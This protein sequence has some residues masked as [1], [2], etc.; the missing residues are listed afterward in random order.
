MPQKSAKKTSDA[1]RQARHVEAQ[2]EAGLKRLQMWVPALKMKAAREA[3]QAVIGGQNAPPEDQT[4]VK[5][6]GLAERMEQL[7][8]TVKAALAAKASAEPDQAELARL[9]SA[10]E[11]EKKAAE[12][13]R[14]AAK[15]AELRS[16]GLVPWLMAV[17]GAGFAV[18]GWWSVI[19]GWF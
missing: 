13:W 18:A 3:V 10:L 2:K 8:E 4:G 6:D 12:R 19:S 11:T 16:A 7:G 5:L 1:T 17:A 9:R 14:K 15:S